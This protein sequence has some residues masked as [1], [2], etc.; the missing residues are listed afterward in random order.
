MATSYA[1][2]P[3]TAIVPANRTF[4]WSG[5]FAGTFL[6]LAIEATFGI[7]GTA[8]FSSVTNPKASNPVGIGIGLGI[9][10]VILS[11]IA[12][13]FAGKLASRLS[14]AATRNIGMYA[15]LIT[16][17]MSVFTSIL[18]TAL[19]LGSTLGST[20]GLVGP[21]RL[22]DVLI[23][24]GYWLFAA[25]VLGMIAAAFGG[26]HAAWT[27]DRVMLDRSTETQKAA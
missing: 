3:A 4:S 17:G 1:N 14:A 20:I 10:M 2:Y 22:A 16:F 27:D 6:F 5:I 9:W 18:I 25:L 24:N 21:A 15:G 12:L 26:I 11:I 23:I 7:L 8:I 19:A 13:Y